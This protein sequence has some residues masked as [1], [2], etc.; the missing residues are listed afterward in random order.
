MTVEHAHR[1]QVRILVRQTRPLRKRFPSQR[2]ASRLLYRR[3]RL[4]PGV[5]S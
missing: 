5:R 4:G 3:I 2:N 1:R